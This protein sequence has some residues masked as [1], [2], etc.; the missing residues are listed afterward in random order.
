[1]NP[2]FSSLRA[3]PEFAVGVTVESDRRLNVA[4]GGGR[5]APHIHC[6]SKSVWVTRVL[7]HVALLLVTWHPPNCE[8]CS[9][10]GIPRYCMTQLGAEEQ[11]PGHHKHKLSGLLVCFLF[12]M[13]LKTKRRGWMSKPIF[14]FS[15]FSTNSS[16]WYVV[17]IQ[18]HFT[19]ALALNL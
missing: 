11:T 8:L 19:D 5:A 1:M 7:L 18:S 14:F 15:V 16:F 6:Q 2:V 9:P 17:F 10:W 3:Q 4:A 13:D 12:L